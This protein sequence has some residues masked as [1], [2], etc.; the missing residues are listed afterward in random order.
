[1]ATHLV[2]FDLRRI[3]VARILIPFSAGVF[4]GNLI[5]LP[6]SPPGIAITIL[7]G[8][9]YLLFLFLR[10]NKRSGRYN[11]FFSIWVLFICFFLGMGKGM[12]SQPVDPELPVDE[13]AVIRGVVKEAPKS[14]QFPL[15]CEV[16]LQLI[17]ASDTIYRSETLLL[18]YFYPGIDSVFPRAGETWQWIGK[19]SRIRNSG[20]P[21]SPDFE[22]IMQKKKCWYRFYASSSQVPRHS[23]R[24]MEAS[25]RNSHSA[26]VRAALSDSWEAGEEE[27]ALLKA[28]CLGDRSSLTEGMQNNYGAA[29]GMHLLAVSGL[30]VGLIWWVLQAAT[31]WMARKAGSE[32]LRTLLVLAL[33]WF[34]A[35]VTGFSSSVCR[36]VTM[37]S[38]F[39]AG[40]V[41]G[42]RT[43][44]LNG[45][46]V[47]ALLLLAIQPSRIM[48]LGFQ[49]SYA[50]ILG[51]VV[52]FPYFK[53]R[54]RPK[55]RILRWLWEAASVS[56]AAQIV[57]APLV[58]YYFHQ[59]P[60]YSLLTS[61]LAIPVLSVLIALFTASVPFVMAGILENFFS[62]MLS[63]L[64]RL[65]NLCMEIVADL[66]GALLEGLQ[67]SRLMLILW[68]L[69][70]VLLM[71]TLQS[72]S[73]I[74][75][76]LLIF[77]FSLILLCSAWN[78]GKQRWSSELVLCHF[79]GGSLVILRE[80]MQ[81]DG[82]AWSRD[83]AS[84]AYIQKYRT[85][86]WNP[87]YYQSHFHD[88]E[89]GRCISG[90]V[91]VCKELARGIWSVGND[92]RTFWVIR[93]PN[94][95]KGAAQALLDSAGL[96]I[97]QPRLILLSGE[98]YGF[99]TGSLIE[100]SSLEWVMDGSNRSWFRE[101]MH[102]TRAGIHDTQRE[103]AY[104]KRW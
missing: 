69:F 99:H 76:Y 59:L 93:G 54:F 12:L 38:F 100:G 88:V 19:L 52:F 67:L 11:W 58:I 87:L 91:S 61:I 8:W 21:G 57:A 94:V 2:M 64:A 72:R 46:F 45:I 22:S 79:R 98:P 15:R 90:S 101:R 85:E 17:Y 86:V 60:V 18:V 6:M 25:F 41:F 82:Y 77:V 53:K 5:N 63:F 78:H 81:V 39:S 104:I 95:D 96:A 23:I 35:S 48:E 10:S 13:W 14:D 47:S 49:L 71:C 24:T 32:V 30:H 65:M 42:Q 68:M 26:Y 80:G 50:A 89:E 62:G 20:N 31:R 84:M 40:R 33:L 36:S 27:G 75:A 43:H 3:P 4:A 37:F 70:L 44:M 9:F 34:Y 28:V 83:S 16:S 74:K 29:G 7:G 1:M 102:K 97:H 66:P 51:I 73:K 56:L 103:G 55:S 92:H